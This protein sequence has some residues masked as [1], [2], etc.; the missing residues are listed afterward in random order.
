MACV[1]KLLVGFRVVACSE[2]GVLGLCSR[3]ETY[4]AVLI[5]SIFSR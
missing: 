3:G 2:E 1:V 5:A 4:L